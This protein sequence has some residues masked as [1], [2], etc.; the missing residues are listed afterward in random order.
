MNST[1]RSGGEKVGQP[2]HFSRT[3]RTV[4][5]IPG[6]LVIDDNILMLKALKMALE[7]EG[8]LVWTA[9]S[10]RE[11]LDIFE[12][13]PGQIDIVLADVHMPEL[14]GIETLR[15]LR[16]IEPLIRVCFMTG[17]HGS[18][19]AQ[20]M[21]DQGAEHVFLKSLVPAVDIAAALWRLT[22]EPRTHDEPPP[23]V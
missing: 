15:A 1:R 20:R 23:V 6:V 14:D 19:T 5:I 22:D 8:F 2:A 3:I 18:T 21:S 10:G 13:R 17:D 9:S 12:Q 16:Q 11:G 7:D 4:G